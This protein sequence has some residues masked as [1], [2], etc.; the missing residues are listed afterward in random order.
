MKF[1]YAIK[2]I[3]KRL[4]SKSFIVASILALGAGLTFGAVQAE[5]YPDRQPFDYNVAC[6]PTDANIYDRC[7]SLT[8][9]VFN[10]FINTPSYGDERAFADA[11]RTD[12]T[13]AGSYKNVLPD[14]TD[15]SS[16]VVI[17]TYVH[18]NA[19]TGTN[20]SG[21]GIAHGSKV[22]IALP[23]ATGNVLRARSY[24]NADNAALVEDTVDFTAAENFRLEYI[25]GSATMYNNGPFT[26]GTALSDDIVTTGATIGYDSL[27]GDIPGCFDY[28][29]VVEIRVRVVQVKK[30]EITLTKQV[31]KLGDTEWAQVV[32]AAPGDTVQWLMTTNVTG[33][34]QMDNIVMRDVPAPNTDLVS[35]TVKRIDASR[36]QTLADGPLF[37]GGFDMGSYGAG[38]GFYTMYNSVVTGDFEECVARVRNQAFVKSSQQ[39]NEIGAT[40]D[41]IITKENCGNTK[42]IY[43]CELFTLSSN[44][45]K[46]NDTITATTRITAI[47]GAT[48]KMA[49]F[50][51]GDED[52][53]MDL[54]RTNSINN[55]VI[56]AE[57]TYTKE[58]NFGPR[59]SIDFNVNGKTVTVENP[60]CVSVVS[61]KNEPK[62]PPKVPKEPELPNTGASSG[63]MVGMFAAVTIAGT[64]LHRKRTLSRTK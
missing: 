44:N 36:N 24:I 30:P 25:D 41:V 15:G 6:D 27:N 53:D 12:Q 54:T 9:P 3:A 49:T 28:E 11:R 63:S 1:T 48:F 59:V 52:S 10:S 40:A 34:G 46:T 18:N 31:R 23:T 7:G 8:G 4:T 32:D 39:P 20:E 26:S 13:A 60:A 51:F 37:D 47:N 64:T 50:T 22:R 62:E 14:V 45:I 29:A 2:K 19:N 56:T 38:S 17:R 35:N 58:G 21:L 57:H 42:P 43:R 16:E 55:D 5:F 61:V 33:G